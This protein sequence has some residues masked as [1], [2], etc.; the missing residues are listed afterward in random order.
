MEENLFTLVEYN[1]LMSM[2]K[3]QFQD[4]AEFQVVFL[5]PK[6]KSRVVDTLNCSLQLTSAYKLL[7]VGSTGFCQLFMQTPTHQSGG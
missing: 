7:Q 5:N 2:M 6:K 1:L 4:K 3:R